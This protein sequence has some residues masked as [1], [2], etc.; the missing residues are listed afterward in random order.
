MGLLDFFT[1]TRRPDPGTPI[2]T[3]K[4]LRDELMLLNRQS[5][6]FQVIDGDSARADLVAE[7][8]IVD[9]E[10]RQVFLKAGLKKVFRIYLRLDEDKHEVRAVDRE[11]EVSWQA[12]IVT[13]SL[14]ASGFRGQKQSIEFGTGY[15]F[16]E[17]LESGVV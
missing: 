15:A 9:A 1:S 3:R 16:A 8:K 6:P 12:G 10:W 11:Y 13:L 5:N 2:S 14:A 17:T 4:V 7:W